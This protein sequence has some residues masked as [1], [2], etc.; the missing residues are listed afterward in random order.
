MEATD[1]LEKYKKEFSK[2]V[3]SLKGKIANYEQS[4][5]EKAI[6]LKSN[7]EELQVQLALGKAETRDAYDEQKK[8]IEASMHNTKLALGNFKKEAGNSFEEAE[9]NFNENLESFRSKLDTFKVHYA[10][11]KADLKDDWEK[12][13]KELQ[14]NLNELKQKFNSADQIAASKWEDFKLQMTTSLTQA[15]KAFEEKFK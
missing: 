7:L 2:T 9:I 4:G 10:L 8:K 6:E 15:K 14:S 1:E 5:K 11:G 13:R 12:G 3:N